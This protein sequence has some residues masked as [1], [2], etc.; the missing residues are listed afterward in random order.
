MYFGLVIKEIQ[1]N[2]IEKKLYKLKYGPMNVR[3]APSVFFLATKNVN[4]NNNKR[5]VYR[6]GLWHQLVKTFN[7]WFQETAGKHR[8]E[9]GEHKQCKLDL[10][11]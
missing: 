11:F 9:T 2:Y 10:L 7:F 8:D 5:M 4:K 1:K 3:C 6:N